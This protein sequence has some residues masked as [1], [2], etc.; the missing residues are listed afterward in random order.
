MSRSKFAPENC[1]WGEL[2]SDTETEQTPQIR[3]HIESELLDDDDDTT[4]NTNIE[5]STEPSNDTIIEPQTVQRMIKYDVMMM[6]PNNAKPLEISFDYVDKYDFSK[7]GFIEYIISQEH[8][9]LYFDFD[10]ILTNDE[11][12]NKIEINDDIKAERVAEVFTWLDSLKPVFGEYSV[13]GY[14]DNT[15]I[16][17]K[18]GFRL[19]PEGKHYISMHVVFYETMISTHDL[20]LIMKHTDKAGFLTAGVNR[21]CDANVYK[22]V[23]K[24]ASQTVRQCFRHV[25]SDKIFTTA[26]SHP[27]YS[28]NKANHGVIINNTTPSQQIVQVRGDEKVVDESQWSKVFHVQTLQEKRIETKIQKCLSKQPD[29]PIPTPSELGIEYTGG[30]IELTDDEFDTLLSNFDC[31]YDNL[32]L[33]G[34]MLLH[35]PFDKERLRTILSRWYFQREHSN[36]SS[37]DNYVDK[38]YE[39]EESNRWFWSI[40]SKIDDVDVRNEWKNKYKSVAVDESINIETKLEEDAFTITDIGR[41]NYSLKGGVGIDI[42]RF[43]NDL[44]RVLVV[45][46]A[47][48]YTF[49]LKEEGPDETA[50]LSLLS[51]KEFKAT[52]N[53]INIGKYWK[54]G[55][56]KEATALSIYSAGKNKNLFIKSRMTFYSDNT[57]N[58]SLFTGY[59]YKTLETFNENIIKPFLEHTREV[60]ANNDDKLYEYILNWIAYIVQNPAKKTGIVLVLLGRQGAGKT[61][62]T[63]SLCDM[64]GKYATKNI[65]NI[66]HITGKFNSAR[67][68]QKLIVI[69]ELHDAD[70]NK[71]FNPSALKSAITDKTFQLEKKGVDSVSCDAVDNFIICSNEFGCLKLDSDDRRY[72]VMEVNPKYKDDKLHFEPMYAMQNRAFYEQL[73]T[74]FM[75]R[76]IKGFIPQQNIPITKQKREMQRASEN[77]CVQFIRAHVEAFNSKEGW[78]AQSCYN[79]YQEFCKNNGFKAVASNTFGTRTRDCLEKKRVR[80]GGNRYY[81]YFLKEGVKFDDDDDNEI[82]NLDDDDE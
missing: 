79:E 2:E 38:Y 21:F 17:S 30:L 53:Q 48:K 31:E 32:K 25:L 3:I 68:N 23:S 78:P 57:N 8:V 73:L 75:K 76:D 72:V 14:T 40:V 7:H 62:W 47:S 11:K 82:V 22:L 45:I 15:V 50:N 74:Y 1:E 63:D 81:S 39:Y 66:D 58:Y 71:V 56:L 36:K 65:T 19:Y 9:H 54:D 59:P 35:S 28:D 16:H 24:N 61:W 60:I 55:K 77:S 46:G 13:G 49:I 43:L 5:S 20:E 12:T 37:V 80:C 18:Y 44:K 67:L 34:S 70:Q 29:Q 4:N 69:N 27:K 33:I 64:L 6:R 42:T 51:L 26:R 10:D 52:M 41:E